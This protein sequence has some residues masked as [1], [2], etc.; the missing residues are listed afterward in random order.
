MAFVEIKPKEW[1]IKQ[2]KL[3]DKWYKMLGE[4]V[5]FMHGA[6]NFEPVYPYINP[7]FRFTS[8]FFK[9]VWHLSDEQT[10]V[11]LS[12]LD[13]N[14]NTC[15]M[16]DKKCELV[17]KTTHDEFRIYYSDNIFFKNGKLQYWIYAQ[18]K[19]FVEKIAQRVLPDRFH[20]WE[21][22]KQLFVEAL[23]LDWDNRAIGRCYG[24]NRI[25]LSPYLVIYPLAEIDMTIL[26]ELAHLKF[27]H[28]RT[29]FW[30]Y[31]SVLSGEEDAK[32]VDEICRMFFADRNKCYRYVYE[33]L[34]WVYSTSKKK[35]HHSAI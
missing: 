13:E 1:Y 18:F 16:T 4:N 10:L 19:D 22:K 34:D 2:K 5:T 9:V 32:A 12:A 14:K 27:M 24:E 11:E 6:E 30:R 25:N 26:H 31:L 7:Q 33:G 35:K 29:T 15:Y 20:Y 28:H 17:V 23:T 3:T 8:R 21:N